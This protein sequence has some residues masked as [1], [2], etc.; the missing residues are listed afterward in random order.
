MT[1]KQYV[2]TPT[3]KHVRIYKKLAKDYTTAELAEFL[4]VSEHSTL[5][6][7]GAPT[8][9][10]AFTAMGGWYYAR[11]THMPGRYYPPHG[12]FATYEKAYADAILKY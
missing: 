11:P 8:L 12:P 5:A 1:H 6:E 10:A 7:I 9:A 4:G 2:I 3:G